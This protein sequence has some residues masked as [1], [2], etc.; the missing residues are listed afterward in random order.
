MASNC[1]IV[2]FGNELHG[3]DGFGPAV[4][5][6]LAAI[7]LP[8]GVRLFR[9]DTAGCG[10]LALLEDCG[11]AVLVD[12]VSG[13]GEPGSLHKLPPEA[14]AVESGGSGHGFGVGG[15]LALAAAILPR[16]PQINLIGVETTAIRAFA[17]GLSP[18]IAA[19]LPAA[20]D[21]ILTTV[22]HEFTCDA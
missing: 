12:A 6:R 3:D 1:H 20:V 9:A 5:A 18:K 10:A 19:G 17:P 13:F 4:H 15:L 8:P 16:L 7:C 22:E 11:R 14:I 21:L 2:C